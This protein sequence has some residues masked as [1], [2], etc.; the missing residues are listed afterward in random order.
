MSQTPNCERLSETDER[1][2]RVVVSRPLPG[3]AVDD[4]RASL[5]DG[6]AVADLGGRPEAE[7][8]AALEPAE[9]VIGHTFTAAMGRHGRRLRLIQA[10]GA[11]VNWIDRSAIPPGCLLANC[12]L[13]EFSMAEYV[14]W[15]ALGLTRQLARFER[16]LRL[17]GDFSASGNY[18]GQPTRDLRGLTLGV[19]GYGRIGR[20]SAR[21]ARVLGMIVLATKG[22]PDPAL[23]AADG[24]AWLGGPDRL[25]ELLA[26]SDVVLV[27]TPLTEVTRG[28]IGA[29]ALARM[30]PDAALIN[31][32]RGPVVDEAALYAALRDG[33]IAGA[34]I[35]VWW[36]YPP[37]N[38]GYASRFPFQELDNV[39]MTPHVSGWTEN[40]VRRRVETMAA[41][42]RRVAA[43]EEPL[44]LVR[45]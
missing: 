17:R 38:Q 15:A 24:L 40:T 9:V 4:L 7:L 18:G 42:I 30:R 2:W 35:D 44:T 32:A 39:I 29:A 41:N 28:L 16:D 8:L 22:R 13:H 31:V 23:A 19:V 12:E 6:F 27:C 45:L 37:T 10:S 3:R 11:G 20:E 1:M 43:G 5:G 26:G 33:R 36:D 34:A 14:I 25:N 21:L